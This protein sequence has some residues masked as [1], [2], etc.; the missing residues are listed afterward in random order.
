M[1]PHLHR[2]AV[3]CLSFALLS[4][5]PGAA[6]AHCDGLDGPVV[7]SARRALEKRDVRVVL[8]WVRK[9]AEPEIRAAF[10]RTLAVRK[11]GA[12]ARA[13][14]DTWFFE[15][16]VRVH[17][18]GEGAPFTGLK[19]AGRDLGPAVPAADA[20]LESGSPDALAKVL[21]DAT[22]EGLRQRFERTL[23]AKRAATEGDVEAGRRFVAAYVDYVHWAEGVHDAARRG[24]GVHPGDKAAE[25]AHAD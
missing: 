22:H 20:A 5:A 17:R 1:K 21:G 24:E 8:P 18:T 3:A 7:K 4:L 23:A 13:L 11:V 9:D 15:T 6:R 16:L 14:A 10:D 19:P 25:T 2:I 12:D